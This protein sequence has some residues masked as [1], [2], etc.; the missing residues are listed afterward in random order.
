MLRDL[1]VERLDRMNGVELGV[2]NTHREPKYSPAPR[3][4]M[5]AIVSC[6]ET[7]QNDLDATGGARM[8]T[9]ASN[10][11]R[12]LP[13]CSAR[14]EPSAA[15]SGKIRPPS[16]TFYR[17]VGPTTADRAPM[18]YDAGAVPSYLDRSSSI[19]TSRNTCPP[20]A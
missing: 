7:S 6:S 2:D 15:V 8:A 5:A 13:E 11:G 12:L 20:G 3:Y 14:H 16:E 1:G 19:P 4:A 18:R 17:R 9:P 10:V